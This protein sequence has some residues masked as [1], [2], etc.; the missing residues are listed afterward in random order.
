MDSRK[1]LW[2]GGLAIGGLL[3]C[4][5]QETNKTNSYPANSSAAKT[6]QETV[7]KTEPPK[8]PSKVLD[9][10]PESCV[11]IGD[12]KAG[13]ALD[14]N[15]SDE[16]RAGHARQA[17]DAYNRALQLDPKLL[18]AHIG[19]ARLCTWKNEYDQALHAYDAALAKLPK[20]P[21]L[22]YERGMCL[23]RQK[24]FDDALGNL[25]KAAQLEPSNAQYTKAAGLM[26]A[27]LGRSDEALLWLT[28]SLSEADARYNL[29]RMLEHLGRDNESKVQLKL[30]LKANPTHQATLEMLTGERPEAAAPD[31]VQLASHQPEM[32]P[33]EQVAV[34]PLVIQIGPN[35]PLPQRPETG[36]SVPSNKPVRPS[37]VIPVLSDQWEQ[38]PAMPSSLEGPRAAPRAKPGVEIGFDPN[39]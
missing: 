10:K 36:V 3:G 30:A 37:P 35:S 14:K 39:S 16:E 6:S 4:N 33:A 21:I 7:H 29:A 25:I 38:K 34:P 18:S 23:G 8:E 24:R 12:V 26:L 32:Q 31:A 9:A 22:W 1:L 19:L 17:K 13:M 28:K 20:Q 11:K 5:S 27:R 15:R 2:L